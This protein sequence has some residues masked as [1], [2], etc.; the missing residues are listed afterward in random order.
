MIRKATERESQR[1][2][3]TAVWRPMPVRRFKAGFKIFWN[4]GPGIL[5]TTEE[6]KQGRGGRAAQLSRG[7]PFIDAIGEQRF[8]VGGK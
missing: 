5:R 6:R 2:S 3:C 7:D 8:S 1:T 4:R